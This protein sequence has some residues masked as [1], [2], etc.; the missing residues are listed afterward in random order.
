[1]K[2]VGNKRT[3]IEIAYLKEMLE[4]GEV[5]EIK[6]INQSNQVADG[7]SKKEGFKEGLIKYEEG[8]SG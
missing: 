3:R 4:N 5:A 1:M 7:L 6:W 8:K 2:G